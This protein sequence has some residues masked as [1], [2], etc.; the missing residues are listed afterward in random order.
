MQH[1]SVVVAATPRAD[2]QDQPAEVAVRPAAHPAVVDVAARRPLESLRGAERRDAAKLVL[3]VVLA[4]HEIA[5]AA[6]R[7]A[8]VHEVVR[9]GRGRR[10]QGGSRSRR[11]D[12]LLHFGSSVVGV[13]GYVTTGIG[14]N[15]QLPKPASPTRANPSATTTTRT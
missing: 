15:C 13:D 7:L 11:E 10:D 14:R 4:V 5:R 6:R 3:V 1:P 12:E 8:A 2:D 9:V